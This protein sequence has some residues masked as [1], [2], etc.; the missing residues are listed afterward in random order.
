MSNELIN[1][2]NQM[3]SN[4]AKMAKERLDSNEPYYSIKGIKRYIRINSTG[5]RVV[6]LDTENPCGH[7][8]DS[9][10]NEITERKTLEEAICD[11]NNRKLKNHIL[12]KESKDKPEHRIQ[13]FIIY[14]ALTNRDDLP[15][16]LGCKDKFKE[17][18]FVDDE[19]SIN[20]IRADLIF[21]GKDHVND[22]YFPVFI[23]LK[24]TRLAKK[25]REQLDIIKKYLS[26]SKEEFKAYLSAAT[27]IP[28]DKIDYSKNCRIAIW[29]EG[30]EQKRTVNELNKDGSDILILGYKDSYSF[31]VE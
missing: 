20:N 8:Y 9:D 14:T 15:I 6:S 2:N 21:L 26:D 24:V 19:F 5:F 18:L 29:P 4:M 13:A 12:K 22:Y 11:L 30:G 16:L 27:G 10:S 28:I 31:T 3:L 23:E 7:M 25:L 1:K 17:L